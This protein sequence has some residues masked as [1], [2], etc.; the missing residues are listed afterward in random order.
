VGATSAGDD[1]FQKR[2][3]EFEKPVAPPSADTAM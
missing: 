2:M 3:S 1:A